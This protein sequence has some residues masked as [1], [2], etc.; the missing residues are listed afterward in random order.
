[1]HR[2]LLVFL[3]ALP[4]CDGADDSGGS[5]D[6][7][8]STTD[9][10]TQAAYNEACSQAEDFLVS[11]YSGSYFVQ[12]LCTAQAVENNTDAAACGQEIDDCINTPPPQIQAGIDSLLGQAAC[13]VIDINPGACS[14]PLSKLR[15]CLSALEAELTSVQYTLTCAAVGQTLDG[16]DI[17][18]FPSECV[19]LESDC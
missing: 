11:Q 18:D 1:M 8:T 16:W 6:G 7:G 3:L 2:L 4:A 19:A 12:A 10:I 17:V 9:R 15:D 13:A 5:A 14:S